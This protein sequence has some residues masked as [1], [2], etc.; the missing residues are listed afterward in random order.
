MLK[1]SN[2]AVWEIDFV[3]PKFEIIVIQIER[4]V[5]NKNM[6]GQCHDGYLMIFN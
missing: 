5:N 2:V 4:D 1:K 6:G 3:S